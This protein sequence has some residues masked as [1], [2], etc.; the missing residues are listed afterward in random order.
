MINLNGILLKNL[1]IIASGPVKYGLGYEWYENPISWIMNKTHRLKLELFGAVITKTLTL[2]PHVGNYRWYVPLR[3]LRPLELLHPFR[4]NWVNRFGWTNC[5]IDEFIEK[6]YPKIKLD[7]LIVSIGALADVNELLV[8]IKK[9]NTLKNIRA[10][11]LNISCTNV[12][13]MFRNDLNE[14]SVLFRQAAACSLHPLIVKLGPDK[15]VIAKAQIAEEAG[16]DALS[17]INTVPAYIFG[18]GH[19]GK[20]G[21]EIKATA[22]E[23]IEKVAKVVS[24]PIIGGGGIKSRGDCDEFLAAGATAL[25]IGSLFILHPLRAQ[26]I[27]K[28]FFTH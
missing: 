20:S 9:L 25:S 26:K 4:G 8:M 22:L 17:L 18:F 24:I 11:E 27:I 1:I 5:G 28:N 16:I 23:V 19:C 13:I 2:N 6:I 12:E 10:I 21:P 15:D 7:N 14:L 3:V